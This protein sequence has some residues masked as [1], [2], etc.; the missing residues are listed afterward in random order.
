MDKEII[1]KRIFEEISDAMENSLGGQFNGISEKDIVEINEE[2]KTFTIRFKYTIVEEDN[3]VG[4]C[5]Y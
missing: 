3:Y 5:Y 2:D 4:L 1:K